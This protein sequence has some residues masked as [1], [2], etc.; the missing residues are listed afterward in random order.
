MNQQKIEKAIRG[1]LLAVFFLPLIITPGVLFPHLSGKE[2]IFETIIGLSFLVFVFSGSGFRLNITAVFYVFGAY[3]LIRLFTGFL[4]ENPEKSFWGDQMRGTGTIFFIFLFLFFLLLRQALLSRGKQLQFLRMIAV[5]GGLG[6]I[7]GFAQKFTG[8]GS[9]LFG[10]SGDWFFG[11]FGN[12]SFF[13]GYLVL[14]IFFTALLF[15]RERGRKIKIFLTVVIVAET[16]ALFAAGSRGAIMGLFLGALTTGLILLIF[17]RRRFARILGIA[18][19]VLP[20]VLIAA[21][22]FIYFGLGRES[23]PG[24]A[25]GSLLREGTAETRIINWQIAL[26]GFKARPLLGWGPENYEIM[27]S[28][29]YRPELLKYSYSETWSDRP[30][31]LVLEIAGSSGIVGLISF[32]ALFAIPIWLICRRKISQLPD[33]SFQLPISEAGLLAGGLMGYL[34]QGFFLFDTF[35]ALILFAAMLAFIDVQIFS[36]QSA[37]APGFVLGRAGRYLSFFVILWLL[38]AGAILPVKASYYAIRAEKDVVQRDFEKFKKDFLSALRTQTALHDEIAKIFADDILKGDAAGVI[39]VP[40]TKSILPEFAAYLEKSANAHPQVYPL[41]YRSAQIFSLAGEYLDGAYFQKSEEMFNRAE[42]LA[43]GRQTTAIMRVQME[44]ARG[45]AAEAVARAKALSLANP[46]H[47]ESYWMYGMALVAAGEYD[48]AEVA[49][50]KAAA[51]NYVSNLQDVRASVIRR[52][53]FV[54]DFYAS[55]G[56]YEKIIPILERLSLAEPN[57]AGLHL[58]LAA[59]Y[60]SVGRFDEARAEAFK[61]ITLDPGR[62]AD[63]EEF[64]GAVEDLSNRQ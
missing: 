21:S 47:G 9:R 17:S 1:A 16:A 54:V 53:N 41:V 4:G 10:S 27:F 26:D 12:P 34:G 23:A 55:R 38:W 43:P 31:N 37:A 61:A 5:S 14:I 50:D 33:S 57:D 15:S 32:I 45:N 7:I 56:K 40:V 13:A 58:R 11:S 22:L 18:G 62:R 64:I 6:T 2:A 39:P 59:V 51:T 49:F 3:I 28:R 63:V 20:I 24:K 44:L 52:I 19:V 25:L 8:A 42:A 30:H 29:F 35:G 46:E 36:E 60:A 48:A